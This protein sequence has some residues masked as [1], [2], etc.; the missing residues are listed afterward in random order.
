MQ[1]AQFA[2]E[3][4][5]IDENAVKTAVAEFYAIL[6]MFVEG[7]HRASL[8]VLSEWRH[9]RGGANR[10]PTPPTLMSS[11]TSKEPIKPVA[12]SRGRAQPFGRGRRGP[13][14]LAQGA[15]RALL[16]NHAQHAQ[17]AS[18]AQVAADLAAPNFSESYV[19]G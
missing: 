13:G 3:N 2:P 5:A 18:D 6:V 7:V 4:Q 12:P 17:G 9:Q 15:I 14:D 11:G 19:E 10:I 1:R 16:Q 8:L